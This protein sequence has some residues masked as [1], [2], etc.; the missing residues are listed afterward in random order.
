MGFQGHNVNNIAVSNN[1]PVI[2]NLFPKASWKNCSFLMSTILKT[3][4]VVH[5]GNRQKVDP[6]FMIFSKSTVVPSQQ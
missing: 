5:I 1:I 6:C 2:K 4:S 3:A